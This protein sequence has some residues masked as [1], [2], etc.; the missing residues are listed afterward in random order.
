M[1]TVELKWNNNTPRDSCIPEGTY[2]VTP[3]TSPK[4]GKH[5]LINNVPNR[6]LCLFHSANYARELLGCIAPGLTH[7]DID[8][9]GNL[10]VTSSKIAMDTLLYRF[11]E[12]F[13]VKIVSKK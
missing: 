11:P 9:D 2:K 1:C 7:K 6:D 5:F 10:D 8:G 4:H 3:R 13:E 12:G